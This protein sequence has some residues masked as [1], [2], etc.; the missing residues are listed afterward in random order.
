MCALKVLSLPIMARKITPKTRKRKRV[1]L[2]IRIDADLVDIL[3]GWAAADGIPRNQ[4]CS[5]LLR[6]MAIAYDGGFDDLEKLGAN[7]FG[8]DLERSVEQIVDK[9]VEKA[10]AR[11]RTRQAVGQLALKKTG[12]KR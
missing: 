3:T 9:A 7:L 4:L 2:N 11:S 5:Q 6:T 12:G 1:Q 8:P 10:L